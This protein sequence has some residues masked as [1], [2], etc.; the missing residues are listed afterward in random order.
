MKYLKRKI[1]KNKKKPEESENIILLRGAQHSLSA[2]VSQKF[3]PSEVA[4]RHNRINENPN[5][6]WT[7]CF[8]FCISMDRVLVA[9]YPINHLIRP[10]SFRI[11]YC[12]S[13]GFTSKLNPVK[14]RQKLSS[15]W[16][17]R[18]MASDSADSSSSSFA[19]SVESDPSDKTSARYVNSYLRLLCI[20]L[21]L[22]NFNW[23][24]CWCAIYYV[25]RCDE[26]VKWLDNLLCPLLFEH[27]YLK[28]PRLFRVLFF[29]EAVYSLR[30]SVWY[31]CLAKQEEEN[32][33]VWVNAWA[34][35]IGCLCYHDSKNLLSI[36]Y[37]KCHKFLSYA[38]HK[39]SSSFVI[40]G[41][42][43][44]VHEYVVLD[45]VEGIIS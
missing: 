11:D 22:K 28:M 31:N 40:F 41:S 36:Q 34:G 37:C 13:T 30:G 17:W 10:H 33:R 27:C 44:T 43:L 6:I 12:W 16:R 32:D 2:S 5:N 7:I 18:S 19:P 45:M 25:D 21:W 26:I 39:F 23:N 1:Q 14:E 8:F 20:W 42:L 3:F 24:N 35:L 29:S 4:E 38:L 15:R 9:S